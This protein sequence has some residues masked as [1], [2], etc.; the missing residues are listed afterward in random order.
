MSVFP[1][2]IHLFGAPGSGVSTLGRTL[3]ARLGYP[4]FDTDDYY[5]FTGDELPY[6]RKRNPDHRRQ[7]LGHDL[8]RAGEQWVLSGS[9]CGW[10][11]VF[12]PRFDLA[13]YC[14]L[15]AA[16]RLER[17][18]KRETARYGPERLA[19]GGDLHLVFEKFLRWAADYDLPGDS[20]RSRDKELEWLNGL[21]CPVLRLEEDR[22]LEWQVERI[23]GIGG[24]Q[25][26]TTEVVG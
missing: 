10:G 16:L 15:P 12:I 22:D 9:M 3:A 19:E 18:R 7:L 8:D 6:K 24:D 14:W 1:Q 5:W 26:P 17:I 21:S 13:V 23:P 4:F 20:W 2:R 11:D 25:V